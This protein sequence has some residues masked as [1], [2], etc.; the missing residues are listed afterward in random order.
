MVQTDQK[1]EGIMEK[2]VIV[3]TGA[4]GGIGIAL[5]NG[6]MTDDNRIVA[7][8]HERS[9]EMTE[10]DNF[11]LVHADLRF[12]SEIKAMVESIMQSFG[13]IDVLINNAGISRSA[14]SW[15]TSNQDW[16]ET[17]AIN[18]NAPFYLCREIIPIMR[19]QKSGRIL[20]MSSV[21]AQTG[22]VGT[23]AYAASKAGLI[24]LT[25]TLARELA[26]AGITVNALALGYFNTGIISDVP[27]DSL[28]SIL[29]TIPTG[30]L[31]QPDLIVK[32][33]EWLISEE[34]SY[35]TGQVINLNGGMY[36]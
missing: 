23:S 4:S 26:T 28:A 10:T 22:A 21:V 25:K 17:M 31:G 19:Q 15:K 33:I 7:H 27:E 32:T 12:E 2:K 8:F 35:V 29:R 1:S 24:G 3:I 36:S 20:N 9:I 13:R 30:K 34:A 5:T 14:M 16:Q 11:K 18:L 6:L